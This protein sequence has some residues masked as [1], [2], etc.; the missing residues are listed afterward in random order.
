M[1][2]VKKLGIDKEKIKFDEKEEEMLPFRKVKIVDGEV[3][4]A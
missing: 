1:I 4:A 2:L 3:K